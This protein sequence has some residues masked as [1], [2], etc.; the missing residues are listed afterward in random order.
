MKCFLLWC[1]ALRGRKNWFLGFAKWFFLWSVAPPARGAGGIP[2]SPL[3]PPG[4]PIPPS[5]GRGIPPDPPCTGKGTFPCL[6]TDRGRIGSYIWFGLGPAT[7]RVPGRARTLHGSGAEARI[8]ARW[9]CRDGP[10][11]ITP[12]INRRPNAGGGISCARPRFRQRRIRGSRSDLAFT[13]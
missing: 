3:C 7:N 5:N 8:A 2:T 9:P 11:A 4:P 6:S 1:I 12:G 13:K 10:L